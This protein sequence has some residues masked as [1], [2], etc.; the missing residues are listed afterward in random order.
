MSA[1]K[2]QRKMVD[3]YTVSIDSLKGWG[4]VVI[5]LVLA[6]AGVLGY[7]FLDRMVLE[8]EVA[9]VILEAEDLLR[10]VRSEGAINSYREEYFVARRHLE[11]AVQH[12]E[13]RDLR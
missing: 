6:V 5:L 7:R 2:K 1:E 4:F 13:R 8:K 10:T 9:R 12:E 11:E 3:W